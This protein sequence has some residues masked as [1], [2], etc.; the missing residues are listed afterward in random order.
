MRSERPIVGSLTVA[1][2]LNCLPHRYLSTRVCQAWHQ[3]LPAIQQCPPEIIAKIE[4]AAQLK[5]DDERLKDENRRKRAVERQRERRVAQK[6]FMDNDSAMDDT[7]DPSRY[8]ALPSEEREKDCRRAFRNCSSNSALKQEVCLAC[9]RE[10]FAVE[11]EE[12]GLEDVPNSQRLHPSKPHPAHQL[13]NGMLVVDE[14]I[15]RTNHRGW[16]CDTCLLS[17]RKNQTPPLSLANSMWIGSIPDVLATLTFPE[18]L[19]VALHYP[20]CFV[21]KLYP[22]NAAGGGSHP[23]HLQRS[24]AGNVTCYELNTG[25][26][27]DM[28]EGNL[29]PRPASVLASVLAV[30]FVGSKTLPKKWLRQTFR[31]RR[32]RVY[33]GLMWLKDHNP[34]YSA[35]C[36]SAD[37]LAM[38]PE[39]GIP[40]ELS[41]IVRHEKDEG[42]A[43]QESAGYVPHPQR[44]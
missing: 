13:Y 24:M 18:Q 43:E 34:M 32:R 28:L 35:I 19:L 42:V 27:V 31:V 15:N 3:L 26:V 25:S 7:Y 22:K 8:L 2:V 5:R 17:L 39:D 38:L 11:G 20:R 41:A 44:T 21:F 12:I 10:M 29:M 36:V 33:E 9:G 40:E 1:E 16:I 37:R 23:A 4:V 14:H 6:I 30:T